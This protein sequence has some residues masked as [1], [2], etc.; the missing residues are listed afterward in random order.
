[1]FYTRTY[2]P[3]K[4]ASISG[5]KCRLRAD[6]HPPRI[7]ARQQRARESEA[8]AAQR[9]RAG[10]R[11][12]GG[13]RSRARLLTRL[14]H[15][16]GRG[17]DRPRVEPCR[18]AHVRLDTRRGGRMRPREPHRSGGTAAAPRGGSRPRGKYRREPDHGAAAQASCTAE[19]RL[20][21]HLRARDHETGARRANVLHRHAAGSHRDRPGRGAEGGSRDALP[22]ADRKHSARHVHE[23]RRGAVHI[24]LHESAGRGAARLHAGGM[25]RAARARARWHPSRRSPESRSPRPRGARAGQSHALRVPVHRA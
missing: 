24:A 11:G 5:L 8:R 10:V 22:V 12:R 17:R 9:A 15:R 21:V 4:H 23:Q 2:V 7:R 20:D 25:G 1:M 3:V 16:H 19:G 13:T 14:H 18:R 6:A